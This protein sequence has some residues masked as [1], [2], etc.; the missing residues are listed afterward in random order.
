MA[1]SP[2]T[3]Q[4]E[5]EAGHSPPCSAGVE[6]EWSYTSTLPHTNKERTEAALPLTLPLFL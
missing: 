1:L 4:M 6:N 2:G 3:K 5:C